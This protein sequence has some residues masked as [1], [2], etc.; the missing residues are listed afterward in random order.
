MKFQPDPA[1]ILGRK[2]L[3]VITILLTSSVTF[4]ASVVAPGLPA[5]YEEFS[6]VPEA[7][8]LTRLVLTIPMLFIALAGPFVGI[9]IDIYG[10]RNTLILSTIGF[11]I[12]GLSGL[13]LESLMSILIGR[14]F[15]GIFLVAILTSVTALIGDYYS[16]NQRNRIAGLQAAFI[17]FGTLTYT[18]IAGF[19]TEIHWRA[20]FAIFAVAFLLIIPM[21][22]S[23]YE[24]TEN[25]HKKIIKPTKSIPLKND[26]SVI[27]GVYM[28][29]F[30]TM[31]ILFMIPAQTPFFLLD[32]GVN[33][34]ARAG[35]AVGIFSL[36]SGIA[37]LAFPWLRK[38]FSVSFIF[39]LIFV[40]VAVGYILLGMATNFYD[41]I[42]AMIV[43][44][45]SMGLFSPNA[46]LVILSRI[47]SAFRGRALSVLVAVFFLGQFASPFYSLPLAKISSLGDSY[48][49]SGYILACIGVFF[50]ILTA[51]NRKSILR[52]NKT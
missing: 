26:W 22:L 37:S 3:R 7:E 47:T 27:G 6:H 23:L 46:N 4:M 11:G 35:I 25:N 36:S 42:L 17:A 28:I 14:A 31:I 33:S 1:R 12:S 2:R 51:Y 19:L 9:V 20:G 8:L 21:I 43:G 50:I 39:A 49:I 24:P 34:A 5:I 13:I 32:I 48:L 29:T 44:G 45:F 30:I 18:I 16:G 38:H 41:V 52:G 40:D 15:L 10:R